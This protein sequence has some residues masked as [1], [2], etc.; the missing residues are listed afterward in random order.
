MKFLIIM[1]KTGL[2]L[3]AG[4]FNWILTGFPVTREN[5][6]CK[7][8]SAS[9]VPRYP[10]GV[11]M[12]VQATMAFKKYTAQF[13]VVKDQDQALSVFERYECISY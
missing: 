12:G 6:F 1:A 13:C 3:L 7:V 10:H 5:F 9:G 2:P 11:K 8:D 4:L